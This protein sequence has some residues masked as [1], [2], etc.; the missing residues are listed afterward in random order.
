MNLGPASPF[1]ITASLARA[2]AF[3]AQRLGFDL[4]HSMPDE[5]PFFAIVGKDSAQILLKEIEAVP[6][7]PNPTRHPWVLWDAFIHVDD[8]QAYATALHARKTRFHTPFQRT[9]DNLLGFSVADPDGY[10]LFFG[11]PA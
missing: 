11:R 9:S 1:F 10:V 7:M 4:R 2:V 3:Y 6:P 8:P 5:N